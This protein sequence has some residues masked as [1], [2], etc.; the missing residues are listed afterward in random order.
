MYK[1]CPSKHH[2]DD[3]QHMHWSQVFLFLPP[4]IALGATD[5]ATPVSYGSHQTIEP[6]DRMFFDNQD[7]LW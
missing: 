2:T 3:R 7:T 4:D 6:F 5:Q 1:N